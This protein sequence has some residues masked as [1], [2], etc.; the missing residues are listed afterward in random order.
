[1]DE[2]YTLKKGRGTTIDHLYIQS[3]PIPPIKTDERICIITGINI[4]M[5]KDDSFMLSHTG[6]KYYYN[7]DRKVYNELI[8][9]Y[10]P[11]E[12]KHSHIKKQIEKTAHAIRCRKTNQETKQKRI[13]PENQYRLFAL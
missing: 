5:Q 9:K 1:L 2:S 13:Y 10:C 3:I 7:T 4:S 11:V 8:L 6:L 12:F